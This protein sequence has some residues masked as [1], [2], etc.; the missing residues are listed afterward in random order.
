MKL[1]IAKK[2]TIKNAIILRMFQEDLYLLENI[3]VSKIYAGNYFI[4]N[5]VK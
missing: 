1:K 3:F 2:M 4:C 5:F